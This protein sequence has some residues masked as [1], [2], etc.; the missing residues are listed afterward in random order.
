MRD[1]RDGTER[2]KKRA[3]A[4]MQR[5]KRVRIT[6]GC[7]E[8]REATAEFYIFSRKI[9]MISNNFGH[10]VAAAA[11][12]DGLRSASLLSSLSYNF[13]IPSK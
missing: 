12:H 6:N 8:R 2:E 13:H 4:G 9:Q 5:T 10:F 11:L 3:R 1:T 7:N